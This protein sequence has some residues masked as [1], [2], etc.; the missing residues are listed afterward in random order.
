VNQVQPGLRRAGQRLLLLQRLN[1]GQQ[2]P[3]SIDAAQSQDVR[4]LSLA[5]PLLQQQQPLSGSPESWL[6]LIH[7]EDAAAAVQASLRGTSPGKTWLVS[8]DEPVRRGDY[9]RF[10]AAAVGAPPPVFDESQPSRRGAGGLNKRCRSDQVKLDLSLTWQYPTY[11]DGV[12]HALGL[13]RNT[14]AQ[15]L[16]VFF[17][18]W[19]NFIISFGIAFWKGRAFFC[20]CLR[21]W[22]NFVAGFLGPFRDWAIMLTSILDSEI[23]SLRYE[24]GESVNRS[25]NRGLIQSWFAGLPDGRPGCLITDQRD[26]ISAS[27]FDTPVV[28]IQGIPAFPAHF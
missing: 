15:G 14:A 22:G 3:W 18:V 6:N 19:P 8:D 25:F 2:P 10:L 13:T 27:Q 9:Y 24:A 12:P 28:A 26:T 21:R 17:F 7:V 1:P 16:W 11:R 4:R 23:R 20:I 5:T